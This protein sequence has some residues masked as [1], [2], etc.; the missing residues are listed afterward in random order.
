MSEFTELTVSV[1]KSLSKE[2]KKNFGFFATPQSHVNTLCDTVLD[3][4]AQSGITIRSILEPSCGTCEMVNRIDQKIHGTNITAI[5]YNHT[6]YHAITR[7]GAVSFRNNNVH[8]VNADFLKYNADCSEKFDLVFGNPPYFVCKKEDVPPQ[9]RKYVSGRPNIFGIF[10]VHSIEMLNAGGILAF[11]IPKSFLNSAYYAGIRERIVQTCRIVQIRDYSK[12]GGKFIDT[13]QSTI[14]FIVQ[15]WG[16][17]PD[18]RNRMCDYSLQIGPH[19]VFSE[20][21]R[22]LKTLLAGATTLDDIGFKVRTGQIVWNEHKDI[23]CDDASQTLLVYNTNISKHNTLEPKHFKND[24]KGQYIRREGNTGPVLVVNRGNGN[25]TYKL[26]WALIDGTSY[27]NPY[28]IENHLNEI[29]PKTE[30]K[31]EDL[32]LCYNKIMQSFRNPKTQQFIDLFLGNGGLSKTELE[33]IF[34]IYLNE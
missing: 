20:D 1:T 30:M 26:N 28:L 23:L 32:L 31:K 7:L 27:S 18:P 2:E 4:A 9:Y 13:D 17:I 14:A 6:I 19:C 34:P 24:E 5:E 10:I 33:T 11:I 21:A 8:I 22:E 15:K 3:Y 16:P 12:T 29:I 25:S